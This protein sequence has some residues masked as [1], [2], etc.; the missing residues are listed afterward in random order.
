MSHVL[1]DHNPKLKAI[2]ETLLDARRS[3]ALCLQSGDVGW[4]S[5]PSNIALLKYWGKKAGLKQIPVNSSLSLTLGAFRAF[6]QVSVVGRFFPLEEGRLPAHAV[7][8]PFALRLNGNEAALPAKMEIFLKALL[9]G[10]ADDIALKVESRNNF[11]TACGVASSAAGYAAIVAAVADLLNLG[12]WLN[13]DDLHFWLSE[14]SRLGSGS[15]TR[16]A[17]PQNSL[18]RAQFVGWELTGDG[19]TSRTSQWNAHR[20]FDHLQH[21]VLVL[22]G[23]EKQVSSSDGHLLAQTSILQ[24][25]RLAQYPARYERMKAALLGG[26]FHCVR[27]L[28]EQDAF[29]MHA[30]MATGLQPLHYMTQAT[31][32]ALSQFIRER[33]ASG[34][35][36]L[37]TLDAGA[38]PHFIFAPS[39]FSAM[40]RFVKSLTACPQWEE[41]QAKILF[42]PAAGHALLMGAGSQSLEVLTGQNVVSAL[43][44]FSLAQA[45]EVFEERGLA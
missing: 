38:N 17:L 42:A 13:P 36:M 15:A 24:P 8:L 43:R 10:F 41:H 6:T 2:A 3:G 30:V 5:A 21:C 27:E 33:D 35:Q 44:E 37:W 7:R 14:W 23:G 9:H 34:A 40:A 28:T 1:F 25:I 26:D 32:L 45:V 12:R 39:A 31:S 20:N 16:S 4:A 29:E 11:P 18:E 19:A 22:D